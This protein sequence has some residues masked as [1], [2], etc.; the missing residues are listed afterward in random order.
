MQ[1]ETEAYGG[2]RKLIEL[3]ASRQPI[4]E[5]LIN[6]TSLK[7]AALE[8]ILILMKRFECIVRMA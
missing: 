1:L 3:R 8:E 6:V 5:V 2:R 7:M 4:S